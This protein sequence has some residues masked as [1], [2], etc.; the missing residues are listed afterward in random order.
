MIEYNSIDLFGHRV[1]T[2]FKTKTP[3]KETLK[4]PSTACFTYIIEGDNQ[5]LSKQLKIDAKPGHVIASSCGI[6]SRINVS[7]SKPEE[8]MTSV[9]VVHFEKIVLQKIYET[10]KP[11]HWRELEKPVHADRGMRN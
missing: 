9:A 11:P 3:I 10:T 7:R 8:G 4:L 2:W 1:F 6:S 5:T